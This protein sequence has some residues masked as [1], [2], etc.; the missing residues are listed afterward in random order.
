VPGAGQE[1]VDDADRRRAH[2]E[3]AGDAT[4]PGPLVGRFGE[5][6][7]GLGDLLGKGQQLSEDIGREALGC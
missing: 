1:D 3:D 4:H 5:G 7:A 6:G 2:P